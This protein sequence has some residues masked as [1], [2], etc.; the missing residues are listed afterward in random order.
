MSTQND[1]ANW[2]GETVSRAASSGAIRSVETLRSKLDSLKRSERELVDRLEGGSGG[3]VPSILA[4]NLR[5]VRQEIGSTRSAL[6][7]QLQEISG[8]ERER[9][10]ILGEIERMR[11]LADRLRRAIKGFERD[12]KRLESVRQGLAVRAESERIRGAEAERLAGES[13]PKIT[14]VSP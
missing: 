11:T 9:A 12:I 3:G 7:G 13:R 1:T 8:A 14:E 6:Q 2:R 4:E 10:E 5:K